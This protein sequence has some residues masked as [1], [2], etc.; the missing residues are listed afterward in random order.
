V[1]TSIHDVIPA[2]AGIHCSGH[3]RARTIRSFD[4]DR[5][6]RT[7]PEA[8]S[9]QWIPAFAGMTTVVGWPPGAD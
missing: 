3:P 7:V 8:S 6:D 9:E 4:R 2:N 5:P 1:V